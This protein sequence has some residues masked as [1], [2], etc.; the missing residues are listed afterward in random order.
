MAEQTN[1]PL[2]W[3]LLAERD[4]SVA[5]H[6]AA[7]MRPLPTEVVAFFCQQTAEKYL[8][9][10]LVILG[11]EPPRAFLDELCA[12]PEKKRPAF[13]SVSTQCSVIS[14]FSVQPRYDLGLSLS[15]DDM[16][17]VIA[18][19]KSIRDFLKAETPELF[20]E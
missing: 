13:A 3:R 14:H 6:L 19:A 12:L 15:E 17:T 20:A 8:K 10:A 18:H 4:L 2:E 16:K 5:E 9:G 11:V 7:T 1:S